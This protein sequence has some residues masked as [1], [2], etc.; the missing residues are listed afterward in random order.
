MGSNHQ[1]KEI[2]KGLLTPG[3]A[4]QLDCPSDN[5]KTPEF[6]VLGTALNGL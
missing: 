4:E 5:E 1:K 2:N 6:D 3:D